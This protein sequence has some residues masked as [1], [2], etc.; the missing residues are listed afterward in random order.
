MPDLFKGGSLEMSTVPLPQEAASVAWGDCIVNKVVVIF[1]LIIFLI[2]LADLF[3][4]FPHLLKCISRWKA[5]LEL[6]HSVSL[7][8]TRNNVALVTAL[9][10]CLVAD[11]WGLVSSSV[12]QGLRPEWQLAFTA[13]LVGGYVLLR[14]LLYMI[15]KFRSRNNEYASCLRN[16]MYNYQILLSL[17]MLVSS[18]ALSAFRVPSAAIRVVLLVLAAL[19][20]A[21]YLIRSSQI[22]AFRCNSFATFLY[23]CALEILPLGI[24]VFVCLI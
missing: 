4:V 22:F 18:L 14:R 17:S 16:S 5:N 3:T 13:L 2:S 1:V 6:E 9:V 7:A 24:L 12:R 10:L 19:F 11:R 23:L 21:L 8:R 20:A 15:S